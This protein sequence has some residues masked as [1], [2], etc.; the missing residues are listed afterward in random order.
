[1]THFNNVWKSLSSMRTLEDESL[2]LVQKLL[3]QQ[4][5]SFELFPKFCQYLM[6]KAYDTDLVMPAELETVW[7]LILQLPRFYSQLCNLIHKELGMSEDN[8]IDYN[9]FTLSNR[10][11]KL[12]MQRG[13]AYYQNWF[14]QTHTEGVES[15]AL[16]L[17]P[18]NTTRTGQGCRAVKRKYEG[19]GEVDTPFA[20][21]SSSSGS[22]PVFSSSEGS[23]EVVFI[24]SKK[25]TRQVVAAASRSSSYSDQTTK[26]A[27]S[28]QVPLSVP[29]VCNLLEQLNGAASVGNCTRRS[30]RN[31]KGSSASSSG[32]K[33]ASFSTRVCIADAVSVGRSANN[34]GASGNRRSRSSRYMGRVHTS[35]AGG[36]CTTLAETPTTVRDDLIEELE[37]GSPNF[38]RITALLKNDCGWAWY[39]VGASFKGVKVPLQYQGQTIYVT[40][41]FDNHKLNHPILNEDYF[42][43]Q[44]QLIDYLRLQM[45][46]QKESQFTESG[47]RKAD[48]TAR[49]N[50]S[51]RSNAESTGERSSR[52][53][54]GRT[55]RSSRN[56]SNINKS[57]GTS[58]AAGTTSPQPRAQPFAIPASALLVR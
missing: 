29:V 43:D 50:R 27:E 55:T 25:A 3:R 23:P 20:I 11:I 47:T 30:S 41:R 7:L 35:P 22:S 44:E 37:K 38:L 58:I 10:V 40:K 49:G 21:S 18:N 28:E 45:G 51:T 8:I 9:P 34:S 17:E 36:S 46:L 26:T 53:G 54:H 32:N 33:P 57:T 42:F 15:G 16:T 13:A 14:S 48:I 2:V 6:L 12:R 4:K 1:M 5:V 19:M 52:T 56:S 31:I 39:Y 24:A